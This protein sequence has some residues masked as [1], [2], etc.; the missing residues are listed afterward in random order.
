M[1]EDALAFVRRQIDNEK[2]KTRGKWS[3]PVDHSRL[4]EIFLWEKNTDAAWNEAIRGG[5]SDHFWLKLAAVREK[6]HPA[7]SVPVYQRMVE[8]I[9]LRMK[10]DAYEEATR[11]VKHIGELMFGLGKQA[12]FTSYLADV[13]LR[14][15]PK[16]N[17][18]KLLA[19]V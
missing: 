12:E 15:K 13:K 8:P 7:D 14:H 1:R 6:D 11:M 10:N 19:G 2:S 4:V 17:L 5:C 3:P 18:M 16:R 9:I